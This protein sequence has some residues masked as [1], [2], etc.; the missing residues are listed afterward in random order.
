MGRHI[1]EQFAGVRAAYAAV[2]AVVLA[3]AVAVALIAACGGGA[4][5]TPTPTSSPTPSAT[6]RATRTPLPTRTPTPT[7]TPSDEAISES[8]ERQITSIRSLVSEFGEPPGTN[9]ARLRIP[10]LGVDGPVAAS[11]V[12]ESGVMS[13]PYNPVEVTWYDM[14]LWPGMGGRPGE[15]G[16]AIFS[17]HVDYAAHIAYA[18]GVYYRGKGIFGSL[19]LLSPGDII[20][21]AYNGQ[22]LKYAVKWQR[23]V[24]AVGGDWATIWSDSVAVDS[25]TLYTCGG[26]FDFGTR[27][28]S[29]RVV[30]RAERVG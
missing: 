4:D 19:E 23:D 12:G 14:R 7:P 3:I 13:A 17:G 29:H 26:Q 27:Q 2:G 10:L 9:F 28:Y 20:E 1:R 8:G 18:G 15:G 25:I 5:P 6:P 22:V 30:V 21:V 16:N 24:A 11:T